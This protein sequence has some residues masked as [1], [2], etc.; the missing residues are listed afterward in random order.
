M[1]RSWST[2]TKD[3]SGSH[4]PNSQQRYI[5][6]KHGGSKG[7]AAV[8]SRGEPGYWSRKAKGVLLAVPLIA[9][10]GAVTGEWTV[11]L[12]TF[13]VLILL[14]IFVFDSMVTALI[15]KQVASNDD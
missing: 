3:A 1:N 13:V 15:G 8:A 9:V 10:L 6:P 5:T 2:L 4:E 12:S 11:A 14:E 7:L